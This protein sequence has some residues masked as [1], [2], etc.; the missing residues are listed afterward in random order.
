MSSQKHRR[1][2]KKTPTTART[3]AGEMATKTKAP[4]AYTAA[5]KAAR[6]RCWTI[7]AD[8]VVIAYAAAD[9]VQA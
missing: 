4:S 8:L 6:A 5:T 9:R 1:P 2:K 7:S 3:V